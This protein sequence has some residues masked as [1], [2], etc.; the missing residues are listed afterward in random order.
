M[1][2]KGHSP[3]NAACE[4]FFGRLKVEFFH[5]RDWRGW[6]AESFIEELSGYVRWYARG[7]SRPSTRAARTAYDTIRGRRGRLGLTALGR[8]K[9]MSAPPGCYSE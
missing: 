5:D 9:K 7:A 3:D 6:T 8:S 1:S 4:G 2:R